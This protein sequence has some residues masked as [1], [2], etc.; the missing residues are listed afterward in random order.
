MSYGTFL[1]F[2]ISALL[3]FSHFSDQNEGFILRHTYTHTHINRNTNVETQRWR[4]DRNDKL[5][6]IN[7]FHL[8]F[9]HLLDLTIIFNEELGLHSLLK[10]CHHYPQTDVHVLKEIF[11]ML[12]LNH[13]YKCKHRHYDGWSINHQPNK[14]WFHMWFVYVWFIHFVWKMNKKQVQQQQQQQRSY[15]FF[16]VCVFLGWHNL[17]WFLNY[18]TL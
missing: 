16:C 8:F 4:L 6:S 11:F 15:W 10:N 12:N 14:C 5:G 7:S 18:T 3:V 9:G 1:P 17:L 2:V 13:L